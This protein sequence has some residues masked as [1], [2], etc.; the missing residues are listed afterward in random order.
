MRELIKI[1]TNMNIE[2]TPSPPPNSEIIYFKPGDNPPNTTQP[3]KTLP[4]IPDAP[5][6]LENKSFRCHSCDFY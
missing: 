5:K 4:V 6:K 3:T 1:I 2:K